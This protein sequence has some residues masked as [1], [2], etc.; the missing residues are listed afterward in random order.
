MKMKIRSSCCSQ[1]SAVLGLLVRLPLNS[2]APCLCNFSTT[3]TWIGVTD[4]AIYRKAVAIVRNISYP[5]IETSSVF[6]GC[7]PD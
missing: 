2:S 4:P 3:E 5:G 1:Y 7:S 6:I